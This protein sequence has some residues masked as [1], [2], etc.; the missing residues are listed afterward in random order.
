MI[1]FLLPNLTDGGAERVSI[2]LARALATRGHDVEFVLMRAIGDFLPEARREFSVVD[3]GV[4]NAR[5]AAG[6]L[7]QYLRARRPEA[8]IAAM[9]PLTSVSVIGRALSAGRCSL[10]LVEHNTLSHQ[11]APWGRLHNMA[12]RASMTATYRWADRVAA[13]S[14]GAAHDTARLAGLTKSQVTVLHNPIP[15]R[16][17][18]SAAARSLADAFWNCPR[19]ARILTVGR[20]KDQKN[21]ALLFR[22][23]A[24]F[25]HRDARLMLLGQGQNE[26]TLRALAA[27]LGITDRVIFAGFHADP[28]PFY[29]TA[30]LFVL[31][32]DY[33]GLP[34]VLIEALS[35]G[36]PVVSTD[37][38][39]GASEIL[40]NGR[41]GWLVPVGDADALSRTMDDALNASLD[42]EALKRRAADF[43]PENAARK[44]LDLLG[45]P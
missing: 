43:S 21:H 25:A 38:P 26:T 10:L 5:A 14:E 12:M 36:L 22:A 31:S 24:R 9:W 42:H 41:W 35:F 27:E 1:S 13:V 17:T 11:Y 40:G 28:S 34:T 15:M 39:S 3:L 37:C 29:A 8:L 45:L 32:S 23:F 2:D 30:D 33:E 44:Y 6:P 16:P 19:G 20:L 7:A 18:P 4:Q